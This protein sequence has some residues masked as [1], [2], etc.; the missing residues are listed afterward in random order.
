MVTVGLTYSG[1]SKVF[2]TLTHSYEAP[3][4]PA[5]ALASWEMMPELKDLGV[6]RLGYRCDCDPYKL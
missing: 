5:C 4:I 6:R 2:S 3:G 1:T